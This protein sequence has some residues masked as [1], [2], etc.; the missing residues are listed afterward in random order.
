MA[1]KGEMMLPSEIELIDKAIEMIRAAIVPPEHTSEAYPI[2]AEEAL[3]RG[4]AY[5]NGRIAGIRQAYLRDHRYAKA[6][7][8]EI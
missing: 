4:I 3:D 7:N 1:D 8:M 6:G 2:G 5:V